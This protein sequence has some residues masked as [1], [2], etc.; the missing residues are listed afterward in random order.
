MQ[1]SLCRRPHTFVIS[2]THPSLGRLFIHRH[3]PS[4]FLTSRVLVDKFA[5]YFNNSFRK[6]M[7]QLFS[8]ILFIPVFCLILLL[9]NEVSS[10]HPCTRQ[11][12]QRIFPPSIGQSL[13]SQEQQQQQQARY[14]LTQL[15]SSRSSSS[16]SPP[17]AA[18]T[19]ENLSSSYD[20][21]GTYQLNDVSYVLPFGGRVAV[22][23]RNGCGKSTFLKILAATVVSRIAVDLIEWNGGVAATFTLHSIIQ[24]LIIFRRVFE[25]LRVT[26]YVP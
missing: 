2:L 21:G 1:I 25:I 6:A 20:G 16:S 9:S 23:G 8:R 17:P 13:L 4:D 14:T 24:H 7:K 26:T 18:I 15:Q 11:P 19:V 10:F 22:V 5:W 3:H 12:A